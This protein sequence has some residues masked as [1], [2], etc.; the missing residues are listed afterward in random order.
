M[1]EKLI[2][3]LESLLTPTEKVLGKLRFRFQRL[4]YI[5]FRL[6]IWLGD[7]R[8]KK[9]L[10]KKYGSDD[11]LFWFIERFGKE[12]CGIAEHYGVREQ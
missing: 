11:P 4:D 12:R 7:L 1:R 5:W 10:R 3:H 6:K 2:K 9:R 8:W